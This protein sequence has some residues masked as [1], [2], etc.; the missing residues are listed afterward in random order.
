M[1]T[2]R[3]RSTRKLLLPLL[4]RK[5]GGPLAFRPQHCYRRLSLNCWLRSLVFRRL[6]GY[7][8]P[9]QESLIR[10]TRMCRQRPAQNRRHPAWRQRLTRPQVLEW[11]LPRLRQ[12][13][14]P[15]TFQRPLPRP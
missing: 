14:L 6:R 5:Q 11:H 13:E 15:Q 12:K 10:L 9:L 3:P 4:Q 2:H 8:R 7:R 1:S